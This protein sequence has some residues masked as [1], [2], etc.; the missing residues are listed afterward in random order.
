[1]QKSAQAITDCGVIDHAIAKILP[2]VTTFRTHLSQAIE[3]QPEFVVTEKFAPA[4]KNE[5]QLRFDKVIVR[6]KKKK[7]PLK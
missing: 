3:E 5:T 4:Q 6:K 2:V 7:I 1:M